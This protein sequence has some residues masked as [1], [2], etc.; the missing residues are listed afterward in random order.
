M[1]RQLLVAAVVSLLFVS[2]L[3][4]QSPSSTTSVR[5]KGREFSYSRHLPALKLAATDLDDILHKAHSL[6][7]AANG[8]S[9]EQDPPRPMSCARGTAQGKICLKNADER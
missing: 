3:Q 4:A 6:I 5:A 2:S 1:T 9:G 8:P 7:A